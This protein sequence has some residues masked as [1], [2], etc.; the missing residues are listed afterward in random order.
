MNNVLLIEDDLELLELYQNEFEQVGFHVEIASGGQEG[1]EKL[2]SYYPD[3]II[4]DLIMPKVSGF[5]VLRKL[6]QNPQLAKIPVLVL[7]NILADVAD[8]KK[9]WGVTSF[10]LKSEIIPNQLVEKVKLLLA[11]SQKPPQ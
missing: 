4:L 6:Q 11:S 9:N 2:Q 7:T 8:L 1:L 5:D 3:I 10:V